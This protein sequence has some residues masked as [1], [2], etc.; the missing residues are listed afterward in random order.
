LDC[1]KFTVFPI[2]SPAWSLFFE[3]FVSVVF[4]FY[5]T[6]FAHLSFRI[7]TALT[8]SMVAI[9]A[10]V[11]WHFDQA[12]PGWGIPY[13]LVAFPRALAEFFLGMWLYYF[14]KRVKEQSYLIAG[15]A[16]TAAIVV[17]YVNNLSLTLIA[18]FTLA[19]LLILLL[20]KLEMSKRAESVCYFLGSIS[21]PL[22]IT[23][24][25]IYRIV[26][27][28]FGKGG[29]GLISLT[30]FISLVA[31]ISSILFLKIDNV[32]RPNLLMLKQRMSRPDFEFKQLFLQRRFVE[33]R[34]NATVYLGPGLERRSSL[35][36]N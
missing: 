20:A 18:C 15:L 22:Y 4:Y 12:N 8:F 26:M 7:F 30:A 16:G 31:L 25:P 2:N 36:S 6:H 9:T 13:F 23:H 14:H 29:F 32:I 1:E 24:V 17:M 21:Y 3:L 10:S 35:R 33:R 11:M 34:I 28:L 5:M 19:P 27:E